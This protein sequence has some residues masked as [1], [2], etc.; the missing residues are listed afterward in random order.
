MVSRITPINI[1]NT[2]NNLNHNNCQ[3][4]LRHRVYIFYT[5]VI[6]C[7]RNLETCMHAVLCIRSEV[8]LEKREKE[9]VK[10]R[11]RSFLFYFVFFF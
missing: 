10:A 3:V 1:R 7:V 4:V 11:R 5:C 9:R 2:L 8:D 6:L